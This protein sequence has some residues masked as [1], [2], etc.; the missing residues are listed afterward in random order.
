MT[1]YGL[2]YMIPDGTNMEHVK[3]SYKILSI[4]NNKAK[5]FYDITGKRIKNL[6]IMKEG[7]Y[8]F[9]DYQDKYYKKKIIFK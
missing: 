9:K 1:H 8:F 6:E 3:V 2:E 7:I 4:A 5:E